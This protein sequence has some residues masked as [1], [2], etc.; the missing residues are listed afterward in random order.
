MVSLVFRSGF[1]AFVSA[2]EIPFPGNRDFGSKRRGST[3]YLLEQEVRAIDAGG[4]ILPASRQ[5]EPLPCHGG[6][7]QV[8]F[9]DLL[10]GAVRDFPDRIFPARLRVAAGGTSLG[11]VGGE[12]FYVVEGRNFF[13]RLFCTS[14]FRSL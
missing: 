6:A 7:D 9:R 2:G 5:G 4:T 3:V 11:A 13:A 8:A 10:I 14:R 12:P 1:G